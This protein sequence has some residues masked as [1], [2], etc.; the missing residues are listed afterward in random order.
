LQILAVDLGFGFTKATDGD[1]SLIFKSVIGEADQQQFAGQSLLRPATQDHLH[2]EFDDGRVF[3]GDMAERQSNVRSFTLDQDRFIS[4]SAVTLTLA[5]LS[6]IAVPDEP[7][8]LV[9]GLP[10]SEFSSWSGEL[11]RT[12][13]GEHLFYAI[14]A[15]GRREPVRLEIAEVQV[16]PQPFGS[17]YELLLNDRGEVADRRLM[18]EKIGIIDVGFQTADFTISDRTNFLER[19]SQS[20]DSGIARAFSLIATK[21]REK[22]GVNIEVYRLYDAVEKGRIKIRGNSFDLAKLTEHVMSQ[23]ATEIA[24]TANELW[25]DDWDIDSIV[26][27]GGGGAVLAP[28]ITPLVQGRVLAVETGRDHRLNNVQ[29]FLKFGYHAWADQAAAPAAGA[30]DDAGAEGFES[31]N[32]DVTIEPEEASVGAGGGV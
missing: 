31:T 23:L 16:I 6:R 4:E 13:R 15:D 11:S 1:Q 25:T 26:V 22:S 32:G 12:L 20:S 29:G 28:Y 14:D 3:V 18:Q 8:G 5:A 17:M 10:I 21:L 24:T 7:I 27:S 30:S 2:F 19:G 9:T